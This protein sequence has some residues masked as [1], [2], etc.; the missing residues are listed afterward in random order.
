[1]AKFTGKLVVGQSGGPTMVINQSLV[2]IIEEATKHDEFTAVWGARE[3]VKGILNENFADL[4]KE[5]PANLK[6]VACTPGAALGSVRM[7]PTEDD[8][9]KMFEIFKKHDIRYF[10]YIGGNDSAESASIINRLAEQAGYELHVFH[11][12][13]TIDNDL[14]VTDHCPGYGSAARY[15]GLALMGDN[16]DNISLP[17]IKI[18]VVMGRHAGFLAAASILCRREESDGPHLVYVPEVDFD[19]EKFIADVDAVYTKYGR[20][21]IAV[22]EGIHGPNNEPIFTSGEMDQFGN[23]QLSGTGMLGDMLA[24]FLKKSL[25]GKLRVRTDTLGYMQRSYPGAVSSVDAEEA[26]RVGQEAVRLAV[27]GDIDGSVA[28]KREEN[29]KHYRVSYFR[30]E[31]SAVARDTQALDP[32]YIAEEG[33][34]ILPDYLEYVTPLVGPMSEPGRLRLAPAVEG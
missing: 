4:S 33:N 3:G 10:F 5:S 31:L 11:V 32:K 13:K 20:C 1:M 7:K 2:G 12:P 25:G 29:G 8:C 34:N 16:F 28:I 6:K 21:L 23:I 30:A 27:S 14:L 18:D 9:Q 24:A 15:V 22:S 26:Y 19:K 17:G